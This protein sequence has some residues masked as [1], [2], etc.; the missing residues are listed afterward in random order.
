MP[1]KGVLSVSTVNKEEGL[2]EAP[3]STLPHIQAVLV[4]DIGTVIRSCHIQDFGNRYMS[5]LFGQYCK[6]ILPKHRVLAVPT[7][8][9]A[10][11]FELLLPIRREELFL[12]LT[13]LLLLGSP[14]V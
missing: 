6:P 9:S 3:R 2:C 7:D 4:R 8:R 14:C 11:L 13:L 10:T 12:L 1:E 5:A